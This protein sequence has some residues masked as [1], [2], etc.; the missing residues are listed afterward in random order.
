MS[1]EEKGT[2]RRRDGMADARGSA[3]LPR[4]P[5][6]PVADR[7]PPAHGIVSRG[8]VGQP[9]QRGA[10]VAGPTGESRLHGLRRRHSSCFARLPTISRETSSLKARKTSKTTALNAEPADDREPVPE[11][12]ER[13]RAELEVVERVREPEPRRSVTTARRSGCSTRCESSASAESRDPAPGRRSSLPSRSRR[14]T[15]F[16]SFCSST[17]STPPTSRCFAATTR[18]PDAERALDAMGSRG[19]SRD[20]GAAPSEPRGGDSPGAG[21]RVRS[22]LEGVHLDRGRRQGAEPSVLRH[23][24][25]LRP[26][27]E[28]TANR[29][30]HRPGPSLWSEARRD[31]R[32]LPGRRERSADGSR[33]RSSRRS[34]ICSARSSTRPTRFSTSRRTPRRSRWWRASAS[35]SK[36]SCGASTAVPG[37]SMT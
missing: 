2:L 18:P 20:S 15:T 30:A 1:P 5:A 19:R 34:S 3:R 27:V 33:S 37:R 17:A 26:A 13:L 12:D 9:S 10:A 7:L 24:H 25:Q 36:R 22:A 11:T 31:R 8:A 29:A 14:R 6:A 21:P 16:A 35:T 23:G 32:Q 4:Q 28:P